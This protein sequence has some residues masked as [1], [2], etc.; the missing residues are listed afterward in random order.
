MSGRV[1]VAVRVR[2]I[3]ARE[4]SSNAKCNVQVEG[5]QIT[6]SVPQTHTSGGHRGLAQTPKVF[7]FDRAYDSM[8]YNATSYAGQDHLYQDLGIGLLD[9][10]FAGYNCC[11][12]AYGQTGSG[13]SYTM[14]GSDNKKDRGI[15]PSICE[16]LFRRISEIS[17]AQTTCVVEV[18]YLEIY[19]EKVRDLLSP[20]NG[21][22]LRVRE[23]PI[24]GPYVEDLTKLVT[25]DY[26]D[27]QQLIVE[28]NLRRTTASTNMN[29]TS[30]RSH[31]VFTV[32]LTQRQFVADISTEKVSKVSLVDLAGS[33]RVSTSGATGLRLKEGAEINRSLSALGRVISALADKKSSRRSGVGSAVVVPY[34]DSILTWLLKDSLG[35]NSLT[36]M[37]AT[38]SPAEINYEETLS[39][40]RYADSAKCIQNHAV[41][42]EDQNTKMIR[43]L[44]AELELLRAKMASA[45]FSQVQPS[46]TDEFISIVTPDGEIQQI[47]K[48]EI[49]AR[50]EQNTKLMEHMNL[51]WE[52]KLAAT[53]RVQEERE[54]ALEDLGID[55][56]CINPIGLTT[57]RKIPHLI[58]LSE[59]PLLAELLIYTLKPGVTRCGDLESASEIKLSAPSIRPEHCIFRNEGG[60]VTIEP[61]SAATVMVNGQRIERVML[62]SLI[63]MQRLTDLRPDD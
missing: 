42:N 57:P 25:A 16:E 35:G 15:I 28:G 23:H 62:V 60:I 52:E 46:L 40:L 34:R 9:K 38:I 6:V 26:H 63:K 11:I 56:G 30:S 3:N 55:L 14:I 20:S 2:P 43:E 59:D 22:Y 21:S 39:T 48:A 50:M 7:T 1:V 10:T 53:K 44:K 51:T 8:N 58:N 45:E 37:I 19:S 29:E 27:I 4:L 32:T 54:K 24:T 12:F 5:D 33:E 49:A 31:A 47:S 18:S 13:K 36:T 17:D 41:V 61:R